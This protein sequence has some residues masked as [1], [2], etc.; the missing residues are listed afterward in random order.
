MPPWVSGMVGRAP[1]GRG[2]KPAHRAGQA[3][4]QETFVGCGTRPP[5]GQV[6]P[7]KLGDVAM[8]GSP[9]ATSSTCARAR[10]VRWLG[11]AT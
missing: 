4:G 8:G 9:G 1:G 2:R 5:G 6:Q 10:T 7:A 3:V 11:T